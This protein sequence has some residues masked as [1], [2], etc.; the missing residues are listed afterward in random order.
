MVKRIKDF[1][2]TLVEVMIAMTLFALFATAFLMSQGSNIESSTLM[3]EDLILHS[4]AQRKMNEA[5]IDKPEFTPSTVNNI[6]TRKFEEAEYKNYKYTIRY[7][8]I[9]FPH[10]EQL[11]G[12]DQEDQMRQDQ[13]QAVKKMVFDKLKRNIEEMLWQVEVIV[14]N[15]ETS[16]S[17]SLTS[18]ITHD[19]AQLDTN[20]GM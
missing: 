15:T 12:M 5:L 8:R 3:Q 13:N 16:Y 4:L 17:L 11:I 10:F 6:I 2:F 1:G 7:Y 20:F 19:R 9:E 18:W 14:E